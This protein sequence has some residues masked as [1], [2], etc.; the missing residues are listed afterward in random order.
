MNFQF[1]RSRHYIDNIDQPTA[2]C[3][4]KSEYRTPRKWW[5]YINSDIEVDKDMVEVKNDQWF[6]ELMPEYVELAN[7]DYSADWFTKQNKYTGGSVFYFANSEACSC[8][9]GLIDSTI[10]TSE[11]KRNMTV[12]Q[13]LHGWSGPCSDKMEDFECYYH[14]RQY[15]NFDL[16]IENVA[17]D[18]CTECY[19]IGPDLWPLSENQLIDTLTRSI[20]DNEDCTPKKGYHRSKRNEIYRCQEADH[21]NGI[22]AFTEANG[23]TDYECG[24]DSWINANYIIESFTHHGS[25]TILVSFFQLD[26]LDFH[27]LNLFSLG[28][29]Q[30]N[31][32]L[33]RS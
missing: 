30:I 16:S 32:L 11:F 4:C 2:A 26:K 23:Q 7:L 27:D 31:E 28:P 14:L 22:M 13:N 25:L 10:E 3:L 19:G 1:K 5:S 15:D 12:Q 17:K 24:F 8:A 29:F 21:S 6:R 9:Q 20:G 33:N 18:A